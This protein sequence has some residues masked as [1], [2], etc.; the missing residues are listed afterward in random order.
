M[1]FS[2]IIPVWNE[3]AQI[4]HGL[5][6][7]KEISDTAAMEIILVDGG[8]TDRTVEYARKWADAI[9]CLDA[10]NRGAQLHAGALK[11][12]G[13]LLFFLHADTQPPGNWQERLE[14]FWL[15]A[16]AVSTAATVFSVDYG[17]G[18]GYRLTAWGQNARVPLRQIAYGD[19]G[20]CTTR[21]IYKACGGFPEIPLMEDVVFSRRLRAHGRIAILPERIHPAARRLYRNGPILNVLQNAGLRAAFAMGV[22]P[23]KLWKLYYRRRP[24]EPVFPEI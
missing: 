10:P 8:S 2:V 11:A 1:K 6:R 22:T 5:R 13:D 21:E 15:G 3:G 18:L 24:G 16:Q 17:R 14:Q 23:E 12:T 9:V 19:A 4:A 20:F 7:L